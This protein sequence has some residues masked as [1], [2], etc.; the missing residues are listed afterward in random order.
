MTP[1]ESIYELQSA[2]F[3]LQQ[4]LHFKD[5]LVSKKVQVKYLGRKL[6]GFCH[7]KSSMGKNE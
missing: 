7:E 4:H 1:I 3:D 2:I 6:A 5:A